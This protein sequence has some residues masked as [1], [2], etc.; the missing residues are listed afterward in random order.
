MYDGEAFDFT[1]IGFGTSSAK[2]IT[3]SFWVKL[4]K[5]ILGNIKLLHYLQTQQVEV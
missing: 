5:Q 1:D 4:I 2:K 3:V